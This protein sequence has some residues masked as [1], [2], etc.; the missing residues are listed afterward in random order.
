MSL[1]VRTL[2]FDD[3]VL[4]AAVGLSDRSPSRSG[5]AS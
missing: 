3:P 4:G 2:A 1:C 5:A